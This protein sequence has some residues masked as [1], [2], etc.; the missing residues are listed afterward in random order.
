[1]PYKFK[2]Q[3]Y[4][5]PVMGEGDMLT[6]EQEWIQMST[7]DNLLQA[8]MFGCRKA[9]LE[10]GS[11]SIEWDR[12]HSSCHLHIRPSLQD[13]YSLLG[14]INGRLFSSMEDISVGTLYADAVY[15]VYVEY[16]NGLET[17]AQ[18]FSV[19]A[20]ISPQ[21]ENDCRMKLCV[22]DTTEGDGK[23]DADVNKIYAKN[24]LAHTMDSTNPHGRVQA[25]DE[26]QVKESLSV[27]G[28]PVHGVVFRKACSAGNGGAVEVVFDS[29]PLFL[30]VCPESLGAGEIAWTID[31][32]TAHVF[33]S[34]SEG[35][36]LNIRADMK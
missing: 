5:I 33:N 30:T 14:I 4:R 27:K 17:D 22:V 24:I 20:Y 10:E 8:A 12:N 15:H 28:N 13:G 29:E 26:L 18:C 23:V 3:F 1:M 25:Q 35:V 16:Q 21:K 9:Y 2:T 19:N 7:I 32:N 36:V 6:E 11:Y 34:G 31:G